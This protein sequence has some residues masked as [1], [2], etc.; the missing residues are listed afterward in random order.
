MHLMKGKETYQGLYIYFLIFRQFPHYTAEKNWYLERLSTLLFSPCYTA[1]CC[2]PFLMFCKSTVSQTQVHIKIICM[3]QYWCLGPT[4]RIAD[5]IGVE[6]DL[7]IRTLSP[8]D[9][10][11]Q[12]SL[13]T[14]ALNLCSQCGSLITC[15]RI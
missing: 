7:G 1:I 4:S 5:L 14:T 3:K 13:R 10:Y 11:V 6:C 9:S 12:Q 2:H 8:N 15:I